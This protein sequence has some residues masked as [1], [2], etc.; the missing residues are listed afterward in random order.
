[1]KFYFEGHFDID[2]RQVNK[3]AKVSIK[4]STNSRTCREIFVLVANEIETVVSG[5]DYNFALVGDKKTPML[6]SATKTNADKRIVVMGNIPQPKHRSD[7]AVD[8]E[9]TTAKILNESQGSGAWGA[10][11]C[12][13][14]ILENG[15]R[16]V[17]NRLIVWENKNGELI[18]TQYNSK[19]EY[20][21]KYSNPIIEFI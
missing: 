20:D 6:F 16:V 18:K 4:P 13:L 10:G 9:L 8:N 5:E 1:M 17:S 7:G 19:T 15:Q 21:I 2:P 11:S 3:L 14:S 12:F